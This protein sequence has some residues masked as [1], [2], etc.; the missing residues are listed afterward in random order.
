MEQL[1]LKI[2]QV[3]EALNIS[4][5][6]CYEMVARGEIPAVRIRGGLR[7]PS[8]ALKAWLDETVSAQQIDQER[9]R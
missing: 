2:T 4:K 9:E 8:D 6:T 3:A 7:V 5:S 1:L